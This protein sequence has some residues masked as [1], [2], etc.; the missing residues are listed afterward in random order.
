MLTRQ[1]KWRQIQGIRV[2]AREKDH[3]TSSKH[4]ISKCLL[5]N[6]FEI[7]FLGTCRFV[8]LSDF[9][10]HFIMIHKKFFFSRKNFGI[11]NW[12]WY[13]MLNVKSFFCYGYQSKSF[14]TMDIKIYWS[15]VVENSL[16][17][18]NVHIMART[19]DSRISIYSANFTFY[20]RESCLLL[21]TN[22]WNLF[23]DFFFFIY[24]QFLFCLL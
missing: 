6:L 15:S 13:W 14:V 3:I 5:G 17:I 16:E 20:L 9:A 19:F 8:Y 7:F 18:P 24:F 4:W 23:V 22:C 1:L 10:C 2:H 11:W 12:S 21:T